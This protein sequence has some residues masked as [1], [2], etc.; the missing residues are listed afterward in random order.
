MLA[1]SWV[2]EQDLRSARCGRMIDSAISDGPPMHAG[3]CLEYDGGSISAF[4][5]GDKHRD[6]T[7]YKP[8]GNEQWLGRRTIDGELVHVYYCQG[9]KRIRAQRA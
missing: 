1:V 7:T 2:R 3:K 6:P 9:D 8:T 4:V 5:S